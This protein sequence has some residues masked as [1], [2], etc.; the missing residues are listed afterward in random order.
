MRRLLSLMV[1]SPDSRLNIA[2]SS[3]S[4]DLD[5]RYVNDTSGTNPP[6]PASLRVG[7]ETRIP[8]AL[9]RV[10]FAGFDRL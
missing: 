9:Y 2:P 7:Y 10:V 3:F 6:D 4:A 8:L 1:G 5:I